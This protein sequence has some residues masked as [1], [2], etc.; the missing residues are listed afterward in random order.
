MKYQRIISMLFVLLLLVS[1]CGCFSG[2]K[3]LN[4]KIMETTKSTVRFR[5]V[6]P[7][8]KEV[9]E[10]RTVIMYDG[11]GDTFTDVEICGE[12]LFVFDIG[13]TRD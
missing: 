2:G 6:C 4:V 12:C 5:P 1:L 10:S 13:I 7:E 3:S 11:E 8:C 9:G